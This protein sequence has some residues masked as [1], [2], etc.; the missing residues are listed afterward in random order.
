MKNSDFSQSNLLTDKVYV[1][2]NVFGTSMLNRVGG[3]VDGGHIVTV[4]KCGRTKRSM[5]LLE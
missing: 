1:D 5:K 4:D 2:L 3:H